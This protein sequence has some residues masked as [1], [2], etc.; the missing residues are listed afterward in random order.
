[1]QFSQN[2]NRVAFTG[3]L[4]LAVF[5]YLTFRTVSWPYFFKP[6]S[7]FSLQ[8]LRLLLR[9]QCSADVHPMVMQ[10]LISAAPARE[11]LLVAQSA[12]AVDLRTRAEEGRQQVAGLVL[13]LAAVPP[14]QRRVRA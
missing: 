2:T 13:A 10:E 14:Q 3:F 6:I 1:M 9:W 5:I 4:A 12:G 11:P 7:N 8:S